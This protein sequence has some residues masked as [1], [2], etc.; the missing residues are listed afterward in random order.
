[1]PSPLPLL[2]R[3]LAKLCQES[4]DLFDA[5]FMEGQIEDFVSLIY[6]VRSTGGTAD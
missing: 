5:E 6:P 1:M 2:V 3:V 4:L